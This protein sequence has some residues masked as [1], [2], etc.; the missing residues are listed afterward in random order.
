MRAGHLKVRTWEPRKGTQNFGTKK[1]SKHTPPAAPAPGQTWTRHQSRARSPGHSRTG[2]RGTGSWGGWTRAG[3]AG[4]KPSQRL[5]S[6]AVLVFVRRATRVPAACKLLCWRSA[7]VVMCGPSWCGCTWVLHTPVP[8][9]NEKRTA[10]CST[11]LQQPVQQPSTCWDCMTMHITQAT[12]QASKHPLKHPT[13][14]S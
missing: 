9:H 14:A 12:Y 8:K 1:I 13:A 5:L 3:P 2:R 10:R 4:S 6:S 11:R 7:K